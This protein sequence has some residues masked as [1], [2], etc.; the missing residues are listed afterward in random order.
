MPID[1]LPTWVFFLVSIC[2]VVLAVETGF[3]VRRSARRK[4]AD[5][6]DPTAASI[7]SVILGLQAFMLAFTCGIV[8]NRY[9]ARK[10]LAR[11][12]ANTIRTTW[13]RADL[14]PEPDRGRSKALLEDYTERRIVIARS[15]DLGQARDSLKGFRDTL[16]QLWQIAVSNGQKD[17]NSDIGALYLTSVNEI[18]NLHAT[19]TVI[20]LDARIPPTIW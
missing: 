6:T 5:E 20:G 2:L 1:Y 4:S 7:A 8:A 16:Q 18:T 15:G 17:L 13:N 12:E 11:E 9:D 10:T 3:R 19:R 14:L